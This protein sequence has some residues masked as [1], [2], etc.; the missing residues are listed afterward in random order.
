MEAI[1][2]RGNAPNAS[3]IEPATSIEE[4]QIHAEAEEF[5][6]TKHSRTAQLHLVED[7]QRKCIN[8]HYPKGD[9]SYRNID[10][11]TMPPGHKPICQFCLD[12]WRNSQ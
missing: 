7:G 9:T 11:A 6:V 5:I 2:M 8:R 10:A 1:A 3:E 4:R 12:E